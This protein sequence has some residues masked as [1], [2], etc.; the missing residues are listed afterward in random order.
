MFE[1]FSYKNDVFILTRKL[2]KLEKFLFKRKFD[3]NSNQGWAMGLEP[4]DLGPG[5][6]LILPELAWDWDKNRPMPTPELLLTH[7]NLIAKNQTQN[8]IFVF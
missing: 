4:R 7:L 5:L 2:S 3:L 1:N 6:G 8:S